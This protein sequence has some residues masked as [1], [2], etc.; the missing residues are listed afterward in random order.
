MARPA[1][2][3]QYQRHTLQLITK[4]LNTRPAA[5]PFTLILDDLHQRAAPLVGEIIRRAL[6]RSTKIVVISFE[7]TRFHP[8]LHH[9]PASPTTSPASLLSALQTALAGTKESLVVVDSLA[10]LLET[11]LDLSALFSLVAGT[12]ASTLVGILHT[13]LAAVPPPPSS[14]ASAYAPPALDLCKFLATTILTVKSFSH[15]LA[16]RAAAQRSLAEPQQGLRAGAVGV[17]QRRAATAARGV[18]VEAEFR[19]KSGRDESEVFFLRAPREGD[20]GAPVKGAAFG[21]LRAEFVVLLAQVDEFRGDVGGAGV[22]DGGADVESTFNLGLTE[23]QKV[24]REGVV[25]PYFDAQKGEGA[26]EGGRILYDM[27]EEDD[28]DEEEDEI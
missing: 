4:I 13:D 23:K 1:H 24:A 15:V 27:G 20:Y 10:D 25:L 5:S 21:P 22:G 14:H 17:V 16:A 8:S 28:F 11:G 9:I 2:V 7:S 3:A 18:V 6:S 19:R 12:F 26:G